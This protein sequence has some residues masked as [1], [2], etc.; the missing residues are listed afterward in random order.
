MSRSTCQVLSWWDVLC[1]H[2][3][4][5]RA[6]LSNWP[7]LAASTVVRLVLGK[8]LRR[9]SKGARAQEEDIKRT[10]RCDSAW[11]PEW[12]VRDADGELLELWVVPQE[13]YKAGKFS[14]Q[15][16]LNLEWFKLVF[17]FY[18]LVAASIDDHSK[19]YYIAHNR[20]SRPCHTNLPMLQVW[21]H[22]MGASSTT[23]SRG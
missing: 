6:L 12:T 17:S 14:S 4:A 2:H 5:P 21:I 8:G 10:R 11:Q 7:L 15:F 3:R 22:P 13:D 1:Q 19:V 9:A 23:S 20:A 18:T 16:I